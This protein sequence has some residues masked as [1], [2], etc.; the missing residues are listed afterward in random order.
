M[1]KILPVIGILLISISVSYGQNAMVKPSVV[2][3]AESSETQNFEPFVNKPLVSNTKVSIW[4]SNM[5]NSAHWNVAKLWNHSANISNAWVWKADTANFSTNWNNYVGP[6][7][8]SATPMQGAFYFDGITNLINAN[9]GTTNTT[10]TNAMAVNTLG[11]STVNIK[12]YQLYRSF[13]GD[14]AFIEIS[15]DNVNW[16]S[17]LVNPDLTGSANNYAYGWKEFS[18]SQ[19][20]GNKAQV[21]IRFRYFAP[22]TSPSGVQYSGG[23]GWAIDDVELFVPANN[24]IVVNKSTLYDGYTKI[25]SGLGM[26]MYYEADFMN[27]GALTQTNVKLHGVELTT[28][29][30]STSLGEILTPGQTLLNISIQDYFFTP[31]STQG[32]YKVMAYVSSDAI[33]FVLAQDTFDVKVDCATCMY[34][35]DNN[36]ATSYRWAGT[37]GG[38]SGSYTAVNKYAVNQDRMAY[39]V[40]CVVSKGTKVGSKIRAVLYKLYTQSG[41]KTIVAQSSNYYIVSSD[42]PTSIPMVNPPSISL[43]F[44]SGYTMQKDSIYYVGIQV[45]G[46]TDTVKIATDKTGI[47][48][49][50]QSSMYFDPNMNSWYIWANGNVP[51]LMMRTIFTSSTTLP[52]NSGTIS[53][54]TTVCQGQNNII[55]TVP[56]I[57]NATS[58]EWGLPSG[59]TGISLTNSITVNYS[60][61]AVSGNITVRGANAFG[62]GI[63]S[64]LAVN[65]DALPSLTTIISGNTSVLS[66]QQNV[67]YSI[68][69]NPNAV[70]YIWTLP[71]GC[72]GTSTTNSITVDIGTTAVSGNITVKGTNAC[73]IGSPAVLYVTVNPV[74][75]NC[76]AQFDMVADTTAPHVYFV[77]NNASGVPPLHFYWSWGDG[78]HDTTAL[79]NHTYSVG[80][81]YNICLQV[82]DANACITTYCDSSFL[83]KNPNVMISVA[84]IAGTL[85]IDK[86]TIT[87]SLKIYPNP[88]KDQLI[89]DLQGTENLKNTIVSIYDLPGKLLLQQ[90]INQSLTHF[91]ISSFAK[92]I[93][94]IKVSNDKKSTVSKFVKE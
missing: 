68:L 48:Q 60:N 49:Y 46:G 73:G 80:G 16:Q 24:Y 94:L 43:P 40:N 14:S 11:H 13:N 66:G 29:A 22:G 32:T 90:N 7:M 85:G 8:G 88:A 27:L 12:F 23:Y 26:P 50:S 63:N 39:G 58:Y 3:L 82:T 25:P 65:V 52:G 72:T 61:V 71:N 18:I 37:T 54:L 64:A 17:I 59:I 51:A 4:Y 89:L 76:S 75:P 21:W 42:I 77:V 47:L 70:S 91:N 81:F 2:Q 20:A 78:T 56:T 92:G 62:T 57:A 67:V 45:F 86:N 55:Y 15:N 6:Y 19:W 41:I 30:D 33:P 93:Y 34:S 28:G 44:S 9:Y 74:V 5:A 79:P 36:T 87:E 84:V 1:K 53:G 35:R 38:I 83:Q 31:P 69:A 10:I